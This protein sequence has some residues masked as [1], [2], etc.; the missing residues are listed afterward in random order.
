MEGS[1]FRSS[2]ARVL[3]CPGHRDTNTALDGLRGKA[4]QHRDVGRGADDD[5]GARLHFADLV[6]AE[7]IGASSHVIRLE[8]H[9]GTAGS[10]RP[11]RRGGVRVYALLSSDDREEARDKI[12]VTE[13]RVRQLA[14]VFAKTWQRPPTPEELRGLI[15]EFIKEEIYYREA[16]KLGLDRDDT[17]IRRRMQQKMEF[18]T[19]PA[20]ELL[21]A[22]DV[23]LQAFLDANK[24]EFRIEPRIAFR[25]VF[26]NP[27]KAGE[28]A[29]IRAKQTLDVLKASEVRDGRSGC[30][31]PDTVTGLHATVPAERHCPQ[32][33]RDLRRQP[34]RSP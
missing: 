22:D 31:R 24:A 12:V 11:D 21:V 3:L 13:G 23:T 7:G 10:L 14:Q 19:E 4:V 8:N 1:G 26:L 29:V 9:P 5:P 15:D 20:D 27:D 18:L 32:F 28:P 17:L 2:P 34:H 16:I 33:R 6:L 25:Q 30:R